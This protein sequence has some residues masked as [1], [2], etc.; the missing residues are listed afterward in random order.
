M[1]GFYHKRKAEGL[2]VPH[3]LG[4][5]ASPVM[6]SDP[7]SVNKIEET[8]D[9]ICRTPKLHRAELLQNTK[10]PALLEVFY[11]SLEEGTLSE[12]TKT[13]ASLGQAYRALR[14]TDDPYVIA[15]LKEDTD[16][17]RRQLEKVRLNHKTWCTS[18]MKSFHATSLKV[19]KE[20]GA[21]AAD[22]YVS[23]VVT[24][25][26]KVA[27]ELEDSLGLDVS[28][29]EKKYLAKA[30]QE[31]QITRT[32]S[33]YPEVIALISDKVRKLIDVLL[34]QP[35]TFR[36]I[37]FVQERAVVSVLAHLLAVHP[38][39]RLNRFR[40]GTMIGTSSHS[41]RTQNVSEF[42]SANSQT[43][44]LSDFRSGRLNLVIATSVLEVRKSGIP[45]S[46]YPE[47]FREL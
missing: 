6:R 26:L 16:K 15:L 2:D 41:Y 31:V 5:T 35:S 7:M 30:L 34:E 12:Y 38:E 14:I 24:N 21:W 4:L 47:M 17:S 46:S 32:K 1:Q 13:I 27:N 8:L 37:V 11:H 43:D 36:G 20:L 18:Q 42:L 23:E 39:T 22:Y 33:E 40:V 25:Y 45:L 9:A 29:A 19:C 10:R 28:T 44:T 3:I